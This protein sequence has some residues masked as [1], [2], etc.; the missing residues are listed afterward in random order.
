MY[1]VYVHKKSGAG[2]CSLN[3]D[4]KCMSNIMTFFCGKEIH[5]ASAMQL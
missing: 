3:A 1:N 5:L 2:F 4:I